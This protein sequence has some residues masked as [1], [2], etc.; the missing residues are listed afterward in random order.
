MVEFVRRMHSR[1]PM[2]LLSN[3]NCMHVDGL[4]RDFDYFALFTGATYSHVAGASK[5]SPRIFEIACKQHQLV[6]SETLFIDD[7]APNIAT[8]KDLGFHT[9][10]YD[11]DRHE[12][13]LLTLESLGVK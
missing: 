5:P 8:A 3:T 6:P 10:H 11:P 12:A 13:F 4:F 2:F 1:F 7:L 9:H